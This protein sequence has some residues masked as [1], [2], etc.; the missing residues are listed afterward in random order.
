M[1][2]RLTLLALF[3]ASCAEG[4]TVRHPAPEIE[5]TGNDEE[6]PALAADPPAATQTL[7]VLA[8]S[9]IA[10]PE[11]VRPLREQIVP[12]PRYVGAGH[13]I[14][15]P[16]LRHPEP[17]ARRRLRRMVLAFVRWHAERHRGLPSGTRGSCRT[18]LATA[19]VVSIVCSSVRPDDRG[20]LRASIDTAHYT[21][22]DGRVRPFD[23]V[24]AFAPGTDLES[25][26]LERCRAHLRDPENVPEDL[27]RGDPPS[28]CA[29]DRAGVSLGVRALRARLIVGEHGGTID[30]SVPYHRFSG[31]IL[32]EGPIGLFLRGERIERT[33]VEVEAPRALPDPSRITSGIAVSDV[34][35]IDELAVRWSR[36][37]PE[38]RGHVT[39]GSVAPGAGRLFLRATTDD[40]AGPRVGEALGSAPEVATMRG[41]PI[42]VRFFRV[43]IDVGLRPVPADYA[44]S[45]RTLPVGALVVGFVGE[46]DG[47]RSTDIGSSPGER[48]HWTRVSLA[49]GSGGWV[50]SEHLAPHD[51]CVPDPVRF[52]ASLPERTRA[53]ADDDY[54]RAAVTVHRAGEPIEAVLFAT[55]IGPPWGSFVRVFTLDDVCEVGELLFGARILAPWRRIGVAR[56]GDRGDSV[57]VIGLAAG[58]GYRY[59]LWE[60]GGEGP[61]WSVDLEREHRVALDR[62]G[63]VMTID[64][65]DRGFFRVVR[66]GASFAE[67]S[68]R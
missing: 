5:P 32:A 66:Q 24:G 7:D 29:F 16:D 35:P 22:E 31:Q 38:L 49:L 42:D 40:S 58:E 50:P 68:E 14:R 46:L 53:H 17:A 61:A 56:E 51:G 26:I 2:S 11:P 10:R 63:A 48:G 65:G 39:A 13:D 19:D 6:P 23:L 20:V 47:H 59:E 41:T 25:P 9:R 67:V 37:S 34:D 28:A 43:G 54:V 8:I 60:L 62:P 1:R 36:L 15:Y 12:L 3:L 55:D 44:A 33:T 18:T 57:V 21:I 27:D 4:E 45:S 30:V 64:R 52:I